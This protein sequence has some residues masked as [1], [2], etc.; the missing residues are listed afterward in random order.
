MSNRKG[1]TMPRSEVY[2][3]IEKEMRLCY[4]RMKAQAKYRN[5]LF[6]LT[7]D[8][9]KSLWTIDKWYSK[10]RSSNALSMSRVDPEGPW[11]MWNVVIESRASYVKRTLTKEK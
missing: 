3:G 7:Y 5:E 11:D 9:Y 8:E 2:K 10:G 1:L 6:C 4:A